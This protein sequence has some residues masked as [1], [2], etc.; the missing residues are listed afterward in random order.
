MKISKNIKNIKKYFLVN[1][2]KNNGAGYNTK[3][4]S[5]LIGVA[6]KSNKC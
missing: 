5:T 3:F 2:D 4:E 1:P 6:A